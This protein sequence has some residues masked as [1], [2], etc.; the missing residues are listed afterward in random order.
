MCAPPARPYYPLDGVGPLRFRAGAIKRTEAPTPAGSR[1][2]H[3]REIWGG[4][5]ARYSVT[6][7]RRRNGPAHTQTMRIL[8]SNPDTL[9]DLVLRQPLYRALLDA[10]HE[11]T[12]VVRKGLVPL[13]PYVAPGAQTLV[14]PYEPYA[15]DVEQHW[16]VFQ[17]LLR[18]AGEWQPDAL[19]V[20]PYRWTQFEEKLAGELQ[21][22][23]GAETQAVEV[24]LA[25][26]LATPEPGQLR[27][28][29]A[30]VATYPVSAHPNLHGTPCPARPGH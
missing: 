4:S 26:R 19:L 22:P 10:G 17:D 21:N 25:S 8:A 2:L 9:G 27:G 28:R 6:E 20:A 29:F 15:S 18:A 11:L 7:Y 30:T 12:L 13:V 1:L 14:L 5:S 24:E 3:S 23:D 16:D